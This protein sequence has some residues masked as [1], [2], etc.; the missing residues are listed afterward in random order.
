MRRRLR[1]VLPSPPVAAAAAP[2]PTTRTGTS[3]QQQQQPQ[4]KPS[5]SLLLQ[6]EAPRI[7]PA[8]EAA[9]AATT[10]T[11]RPLQQ[12]QRQQQHQLPH[13]SPASQAELKQLFKA[14]KEEKERLRRYD[15]VFAAAHG[16]R[17]PTKAEKEPVR[18]LYER[19]ARLKQRI[20]ALQQGSPYS[21]SV[22]SS[23][24][25]MGRTTGV[26]ARG[27]SVSNSRDS[28]R[29]GRTSPSSSSAI[30][31]ATD[32]ARGGS[33]MNTSRSSS[34]SHSSSSG[35]V[36]P[37]SRVA[38]AQDL[39]RLLTGVPMPLHSP[40][41]QHQQQQA[42]APIVPSAFTT[43]FASS[44]SSS[45]AATTVL[46][47]GRARPLAG[48]APA[49]A[50]SSSSSGS[51]TNS[52]SRR[53]GQPRVDD[54]RV[55]QQGA[56]AARAAASTAGDSGVLVATLK[57]EGAALKKRLRAFERTFVAANGRKVSTMGDL[58][59]V[60]EVCMDGLIV[61]WMDGLGCD[62]AW[63]G[64]RFEGMYDAH[65]RYPPIRHN[66]GVPP[67]QGNQGPPASALSRRGG[68]CLK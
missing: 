49:P 10:P 23:W 40:R 6:L 1:P 46:Y 33:N 42:A 41:R 64:R 53:L 4:P 61:G 7:I 31:L 24:R 3:Q 67:L 19:Y 2:T 21:S 55:E 25:M 50:P 54:A 11:P 22:S 27:S 57:A 36:S 52:S 58:M 32:A 26:A 59:P 14:K 56:A 39:P 12:R 18:P 5:S 35:R 16:G 13:L 20:K 63:F 34:S 65:A 28:S 66:T 30:G 68:G 8:T 48:A 62:V 29:S 51:S 43:S 38:L 37:S 9:A 60:Q 44:S 17:L 15:A 47:R 45:M